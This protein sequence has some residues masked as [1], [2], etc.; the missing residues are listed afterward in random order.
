MS[1]ASASGHPRIWKATLTPV[2]LVALAGLV[3]LDLPR[4]PV[5]VAPL[6][7]QEMAPELMGP[8]E[9]RIGTLVYGEA[10]ADSAP[11]GSRELELDLYRPAGK[12][13]SAGRR[14]GLVLMHGGGFTGGRRDLRENRDLGRALASRGYVVAS[15]DYRR[16]GDRPVVSPWAREL[17]DRVSELDLGPVERVKAAYGAAWTTAVG[18]AAEDALRALEW[19]RTRGT[20]FGVAPDRIALGGMSSGALTALEVAYRLPRFG[21]PVPHVS[22]VVSVRG[23]ALFAPEEETDPV[24]PE[25]PPLFMVHGTTDATVPFEQAV[26]TFRAARAAGVPV[27]FHPLAGIDHDDREIGGRGMLGVRLDDGSFLA[28]RLDRFLRAASDS[29]DTL[30]AAVCVG[31]GGACPQGTASGGPAGRELP[32]GVQEEI[33]RGAE[34]VLASVDEER[35]PVERLLDYD[36]ADELLQDFG[37][38]ARRDWSYWPRPRAGLALGRMTAAQR[39]RVQDLLAGLLSSQG[40]LKVAHVMQLERLLEH[41]QT[42]GFPRGA[43]RY[44]VSIF[45]RPGTM[46]PWGWRFEGHHVSL[47]VTVASGEVSVTPTFLG[48]SPAAVPGGPRAGFRPLR[49]ERDL[50]LRLFRSLRDGQAEEALLADTVPGDVLSGQFGKDRGRWDEWRSL[51]QPDGTPGDGFDPGQR[52]LLRRLLDQV[53]GIYRPEIAAAYRDEI[54]VDELWFAWMGS[55]ERGAPQYFRIQGPRFVF[56]LDAS[57]EEGDHVHTVWRDREADFGEDA[58]RRHYREHGH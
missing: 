58:L 44:A 13:L 34:A 31:S 36:R 8:H 12:G 53:V 5:S 46:A 41:R 50:A 43:E 22:A 54:R 7:G 55:T 56:E 52:A 6:R 39:A 42:V 25:G 37:S 11:G 33:H 4:A 51:L 32:P 20:D 17:A 16:W 14:P 49:Y 47:N 29:P 40:Y 10:P 24:S 9:V 30:D 2:G 57:Q 27:E 38:D 23:N 3:G 18:A 35:G 28:D 26:R 19:M 45:G 21:V 15:I 1:P 48:A